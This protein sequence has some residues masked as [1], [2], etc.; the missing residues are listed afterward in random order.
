MS[1]SAPTL[2][3]LLTPATVDVEACREVSELL[4]GQ[5]IPEDQE[6][7]SVSG[8]TSNEIGNFYLLLVA[9]CHQTSPQGLPPLEG[10]VAEHHL[11][12]WDYLSA[13][14]KESTTANRDLLQ[15]SHWSRMSE[16]D[17]DLLFR[18]SVF[19]E[20]LIDSHGRAS[21]IN[22]L[23]DKM[24]SNSWNSADD[25]FKLARGY[26]GGD[27]GLL[28]LLRR[29]RA[30]DDPVRKKSFFF[31]ALMQN[32]G[33]WHYADPSELGP[34]VDYH[35]LRGHLR[36]GTVRVLDP[37]LARR[38]TKGEQVSVEEDIILRQ[39]VYDAVILISEGSGIKNPSQMHY[40]FWN[41]FRS[42]C[43]RDKP[44]CH[45]CPPTCTL[46]E[47]YVPLTFIGSTTR[48]CPFSEVCMSSNLEPKL[49]EPL[50]K[51]EYY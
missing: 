41:V 50:V 6:E 10:S 44:H 47:R 21:L 43:T 4:K 39:S 5:S 45:S 12:G 22:D 18:D 51:T 26:I 32:T 29:F 16:T 23:G 46:P 25:L 19:G 11:R 15:P 33:V 27:L 36:I 48:R 7:T 30:Y 3:K 9:I 14:F 38:L 37:D 13:R 35:E 31:L 42:C 49:L 2:M 28:T 40:L 20:R 1:D 8:L 17:V 24:L 34:P